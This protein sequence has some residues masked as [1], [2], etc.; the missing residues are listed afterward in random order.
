MKDLNM[1]KTCEYCSA[2]FAPRAQVKRPRA[3]N[4]SDCQKKRQSDNEKAWREKNKGLYDKKYHLIKCSERQKNL[5]KLASELS[6]SLITGFRFLGIN[7]NQNF[8]YIFKLFTSFGIR[9][10]NKLCLDFNP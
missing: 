8:E 1:K 3:C 5:N 9:K 7:Y 4:N 6:N 2:T 10:L